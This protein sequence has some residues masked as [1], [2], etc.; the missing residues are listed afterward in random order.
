VTARRLL[1][2]HALA[3]ALE[4]EGIPLADCRVLA[5]GR[6][7]LRT[8]PHPIVSAWLEIGGAPGVVVPWG[9]GCVLWVAP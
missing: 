6:I 4:G 7:R 3:A 1:T 8:G 9:G 5:D 2:A